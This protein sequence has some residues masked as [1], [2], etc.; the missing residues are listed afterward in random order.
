[1]TTSTN[2]DTPKGVTLTDKTIKTV[3]S[4]IADDTKVGKKWKQAADLLRADGVTSAS[5]DENKMYYMKTLVYPTFSPDMLAAFLS[6]A[7]GLSDTQIGMRNHV[8]TDSASRYGKIKRYI[9]EAEVAELTP[10]DN[11]TPRAKKTMGQTLA[12]ILDAWIKKVENA[13]AVDFSATEM[14]K[15]LKSAR[16][17]IK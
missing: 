12:P 4:T 17:L 8:R 9:K 1:M 2:T 14:L 5:L 11:A 7:K 6:P 16:V 15:Y 13:E 10:E 3:V